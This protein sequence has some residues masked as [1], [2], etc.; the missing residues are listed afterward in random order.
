[1][2]GLHGGTSNLQCVQCEKKGYN[3]KYCTISWEKLENKEH[4]ED[5]APKFTHTMIA[6]WKS[7]I[8]KDYI[9]YQDKL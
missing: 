8:Y 4:N 9:I 5:K 2:R 3:I 7:E 6:Y 1:M